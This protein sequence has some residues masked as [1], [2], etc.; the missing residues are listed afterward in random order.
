[1]A[2]RYGLSINQTFSKIIYLITMLLP[3]LSF[4]R[5]FF[6][7]IILS[8]TCTRIL[9]SLSFFILTIQTSTPNPKT[10]PD[11]DQK[12]EMRRGLHLH[13]KITTT[14][15]VFLR[16]SS[17]S[18]ITNRT[19]CSFAVT[20]LPYT[21]MSFHMFFTPTMLLMLQYNATIYHKIQ[22]LCIGPTTYFIYHNRNIKRLVYCQYLRIV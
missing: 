8:T 10:P 19:H 1:M 21:T 20:I 9:S 18:Y 17:S 2:A 4:F 16:F 11:E 5:C 12:I 15:S 13:D 22:R 14:H 7:I 3:S 6:L